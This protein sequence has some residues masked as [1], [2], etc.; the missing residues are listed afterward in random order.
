VTSIQGNQRSGAVPFGFAL[1]LLAVATESRAQPSQSVEFRVNTTTRDRQFFPTAM[2]QADGRF[3]VVWGDYL[4]NA[5]YGQRFDAVGRRDGNQIR[6][7][8]G[9]PLTSSLPR[10]AMDQNGGFVVVWQTRAYADYGDFLLTSQRYDSVG[11][12]AGGRRSVPA[13]AY[14]GF[15]VA[16]G[17]RSHFVVVW[18]DYY[19]QLYGQRYNVDGVPSGGARVLAPG[20]GPRLGGPTAAV[21]EDGSFVV[22]WSTT[23]PAPSNGDVLGRRFDSAG[24]QI[25][26]DL[27]VNTHTPDYQFSP[28]IAAATDGSF[29]VVWASRGGQDGNGDGVF[30][31]R[32]DRLGQRVGSEL[33]VN[34]ETVGDQNDPALAMN[35]G[36]AFVVVWTSSGQ[37]GSGAGVFGQSFDASGQRVGGELPI[38]VT[39]EG[40][41]RDP[42]VAISGS[43]S[44]VVAWSGRG[45]G[46][47]DDIFARRF[48]DDGDVDSGGVDGSDVDGDGIDNELDNCPT[49]PNADQLDAGADGFGDDCVSPDVVIPPTARFG[50]NPVIG[51]GTVVGDGVS[52][53]DDA[54]IGELVLLQ[55]GMQAGDG[56]VAGDFVVIGS[57][58]KLGSQVRIGEGARLEGGV[59][60]GDGVTVGQQAVIRRN[61]VVARRATIGP[62]VVLF[63]GVQ[64]G[65]GATVETG[66]RVGRRAIVRPGAV[67]PAGTS[68]PPGA[69]VQ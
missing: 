52:V 43:G 29:A 49:V 66:A 61:T 69:I 56:L 57:R 31:Q 64:V 14:G 11:N 68:V 10:A 40:D 12:E 21:N 38:N 53:G 35:A 13:V 54:S 9:H 16:M 22:V 44:F 63:A 26:G 2:I 34:S 37:D 45:P 42:T 25:G 20:L 1:L 8:L 46:G 18:A 62:L 32:F 4:S 28:R 60:I 51:Q 7:G 48:G 17:P 6:L 30:A 55:R 15:D 59:R 58:A 27:L 23:G 50:R 36:G 24:A 67:V 65:E 33:Q 5:T 19:G 47:R 39:R 3:M 41:Q